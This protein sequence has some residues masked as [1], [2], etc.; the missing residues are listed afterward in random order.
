MVDQRLKVFR[1]IKE[2]VEGR[3]TSWKNRF[4]SNAG[5]EIL[6]RS[7]VMAFPNYTMSC[8]KLAHSLCKQLE[9][10]M[11]SHWWGD[12]TD[13]K[14]IHWIRWEKMTESKATGGLEFRDLRLVNEALLAK[15]VWRLLKEPSL[16]MSKVLKGRYFPN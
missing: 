3:I 15:Q 6:L 11:A 5:K 10:K 4:L 8:Y 7:V 1:Y 2:T 14:H 13:K 16:L 9:R 12:Q